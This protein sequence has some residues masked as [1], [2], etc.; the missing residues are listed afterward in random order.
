M[1]VEIFYK[2]STE[3]AEN[4]ERTMIRIG[5]S[6]NTI[7]PAKALELAIHMDMGTKNQHKINQNGNNS[8]SVNIVNNYQSRI[9]NTKFK[10]KLQNYNHKYLQI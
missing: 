9:C 2:R 4:C 10:A 6:Q 8:Q 1:K 5:N 7:T 3:Q